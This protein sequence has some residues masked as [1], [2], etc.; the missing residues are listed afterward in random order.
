MH[1]PLEYYKKRLYELKKESK[2]LQK[3]LVNLATIRFVTFLTTAIGVY[4]TFGNIN[5]VLLVSF[6]G[7]GVFVSLVFRYLNVKRNKAIVDEKIRINSTE[8]AVLQRKFTHLPSGK[9][10]LEPNHFYSNDVD[11]FGNGSFFQYINRTETIDGKKTLSELL[12]ENKITSILQRQSAIEELALKVSWRQHFS[13]LAS[14]NSSEKKSKAIIDWIRGYNSIIPKLMQKLQLF[15]S[16]MSISLLVLVSVGVLGFNFLLVW[17]FIGLFIISFYLKK[18]SKIYEKT[19]AYRDTFKQY[20]LLLNEIENEKFSSELLLKQQQI[21]QSQNEKAASIFKK[22]VRVI[23]AFDNRNNIIIAVLGNGLFLWEI[24]NATRVEKWIHKYQNAV[25]SW[26]HVVA[27]FDAQNSLANFK[28]NHPN[29]VFPEITKTKN[30][31]NAENLGHP[32]LQETDRVDNDFTI[33]NKDFYIIT[34]ANMAGKSTFLRTVSLS[35]IMANCGL[36]VCA[37]SF[38]YKPIKLITS[39]RTSDSLAESESYF[40]SELKRLQFIVSNIKQDDYFIILDEILKGT[41]SKDKALGSKQFVEKLT[42]S[43][44]TGIIATHDVSLCDLEQ[45][46]ATIQNYYFD[47]EIHNNELFFDYSLKEGVCKNMNAT[48]LLKKME[49]I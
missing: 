31:I 48:F 33:E 45:K 38:S 29:Y 19:N 21:V 10:F 44:S 49:I 8:I 17:F 40:Y 46:F 36:P 7:I 3:K 5:A 35:I 30:V 34:G 23:D 15:F 13:A 2:G 22:F 11:L 6:L 47:A 9:E 1:N 18:T 16:L 12:L 24:L 14:L 25:A 26:F 27:F 42:K 41:N 43:K 4:L 39:M 20:H 28:F 32:L 37:V